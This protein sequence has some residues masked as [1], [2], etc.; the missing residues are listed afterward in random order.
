MINEREILEKREQ[1]NLASYAVKSAE[2]QGR[3]FR[4][5]RD[6]YRLCFQR[7][8]ERVIHCKAFRR[9]EEKTQVFVAGSGDHYRTRLTHTLEVAQISRDIARRLGLNEDL[10]EVIALAHDLGHPPFGHAG[11]QAL[12]EMMTKYGMS[13]EHNKQSRRV[14]EFLEKAYPNFEGL[15]LSFEVLDGM[16]KHKTPWDQANCNF[17]ISA[18][19]EAQIVN[20]ADE[21]AYTNHD[22]DDGIRSGIINLKQLDKF[23]IWKKARKATLKKYGKLSGYV[24][25]A[26][27]VSSLIAMM[28]NDLCKETEKNIEKFKIKTVEDVQ[29]QKKE[30]ACFSK[31]LRKMLNELRKFLY[32]EFYLNEKLLIFVSQGKEMIQSLFEYY[33]KH[34]ENFSQKKYKNKEEYIIAVKDYIAG[35]TDSYLAKEYERIYTNLM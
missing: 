5:K 1:K 11:E 14:V 17:E 3:K 22:I 28:V 21:I 12:N 6:K 2:S 16:M 35:M 25:I 30:I 26:R 34:P 19:L 20:V 15:N 7:D 24:F 4:E 32:N 10:S 31:N 9:L 27:T 8:K 29:K 18:H 13:F 23:E 33:V